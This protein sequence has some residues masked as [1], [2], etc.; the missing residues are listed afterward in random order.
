ML[1]KLTF[2]T[3]WHKEDLWSNYIAQTP[4]SKGIWN[5]CKFEINNDIDTCDFW[6]VI[7]NLNKK[8]TVYVNKQTIYIPS[9]EITNITNYPI[10]FIRQFSSIATS[11]QD[12]LSSMNNAYAI[13]Y[14]CPWQIQKTYDELVDSK[15]SPKTKE[16]SAIISNLYT[17]DLHQKRYNLLNKLQGHFKDKLNWYGR[18]NIYIKDKTDGL[19]P[20]KYSIAIENSIHEDYWTE[21]IADCFLS[22]T[23]PIYFGCPNITKYFDEKSMILLENIDDYKY[24]IGKIENAIEE[25]YYENNIQ[26]IIKSRDNILY[27]YQ[28]FPILVKLISN[29]NTYSKKRITILPIQE[30]TKEKKINSII[31]KIYQKIK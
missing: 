1:I 24:V 28:L 5:D 14:V 10:K 8:E 31:K 13:Q 12:I 2:P 26:S 18:G 29:I 25:N 22:Y 16:L 6:I 23:M 3:T 9:E 20:Y 7:G 21:K 27:Q 17:T 15:P 19:Y 30:F 11:R 4:D